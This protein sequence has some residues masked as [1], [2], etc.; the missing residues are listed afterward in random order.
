[1]MSLRIVEEPDPMEQW[2]QAYAKAAHN[3]RMAN[4]FLKERDLILDQVVLQTNKLRGLQITIK[5]TQDGKD[6]P[7]VG[8]HMRYYDEP[9]ERIV[10]RKGNVIRGELF[11]GPDSNDDSFMIGKCHGPAS[12]M[13]EFEG[14]CCSIKSRFIASINGI[15]FNIKANPVKEDDR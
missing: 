1:M 8:I 3:N 10:L 11:S 9:R 5:L 7:R 15:P 14:W 12:K 4:H 2:V 13:K 6:K